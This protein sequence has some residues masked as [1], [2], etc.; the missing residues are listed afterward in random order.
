[1]NRLNLKIITTPLGSNLFL[2]FFRHKTQQI[3]MVFG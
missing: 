2:S 3:M 1:V